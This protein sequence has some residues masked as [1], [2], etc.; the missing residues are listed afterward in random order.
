[1]VSELG[2]KGE[3]FDNTK[4]KIQDM[5]D[6][7]E[8]FPTN[9]PPLFRGIKYDY[10]K[11]RMIAHFESIHIDLWDVVENGDYIPYDDQL[12]EIPRSQWTKQQKL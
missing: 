11:E 2:L 4:E 12:N 3:V 10:W 8:G 1:M 9:K 6:M 5:K 7:K